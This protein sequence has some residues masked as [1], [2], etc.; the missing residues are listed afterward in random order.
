MKE[1]EKIWSS[2]LDKITTLVSTVCYE[3][4]FSKLKPVTVKDGKLI[5][6]SP[7]P[8]IRNLINKNYS[9]PL[10]MAIRESMEKIEGAV[11]I[12]ENE[13]PKYL[14]E[15]EKQPEE[16]KEE[17][18]QAAAVVYKAIGCRGMSRADFFLEESGRVVFNEINTIPGFTS[19]SRYPNMMKGIG[20]SFADMLDKLIGLY[21]N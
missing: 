11:I 1:C 6:C 7:L 5:L 18:K 8:S 15:E 13:I 17:I 4:Y 19:H 10:N 14:E 20:L 16:K 12:L 21:V 3:I 9:A 2:V